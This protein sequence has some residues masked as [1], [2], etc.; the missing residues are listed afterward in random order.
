[1]YFNSTN[2]LTNSTTF[3]IIFL[4]GGAFEFIGQKKE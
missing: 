4:G 2:L 1:M 3:R